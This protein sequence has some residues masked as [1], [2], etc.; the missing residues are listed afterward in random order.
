LTWGADDLPAVV[1]VHAAGGHARRFERLARM[2]EPNRRVIAYD[3][4][5]HGRSPWSGPQTP[6]Q[7]V[8]DL[9]HV[10]DAT[11]ADQVTVIG[12]GLGGRIAVEYACE[13]GERVTAVA[14]LDPLLLTPPTTLMLM[15]ERERAREGYATVGEAIDAVRTAGGLLHT[16]NALLEEEMAEH[17]VAGD[18]G[19]YRLR[20]SRDAAAAALAHAAEVPPELRP[21][22]CP[23]LIVRGDESELVDEE[24]A[25]RAISEL[26]RGRLEIVPG[27][28]AVLWDALAET[29]T[30]VREFVLTATP[31]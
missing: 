1:C 22:V 24:Q 18:D 10:L 25:D 19:L 8:A 28:H 30:L 14:L 23:A 17:L 29:S 27:G 4:R 2:L 5:G 3:L 13:Y 21:V 15:A 20:Y 11:G 16:P 9:D 6:A 12:H 31:A 7:H 26:R